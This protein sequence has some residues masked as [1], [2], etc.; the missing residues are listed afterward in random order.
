MIFQSTVPIGHATDWPLH[1]VTAV[2]L[3]VSRADSSR[4]TGAAWTRRRSRG[5]SS[6]WKYNRSRPRSSGER[7]ITSPLKGSTSCPPTRPRCPGS[8]LC[9]PQRTAPT[10][11]D[12]HQVVL[13]DRLKPNSHPANKELINWGHGKKKH[14]VRARTQ[15][16]HFLINYCYFYDSIKLSEFASVFF[17][18]LCTFIQRCLS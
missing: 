8:P 7:S 13:P 17:W 16:Q 3:C 14:T 11:A 6:R 2:C 4:I 10:Q 5:F 15:W 9:S 1:A 18:L 12:E